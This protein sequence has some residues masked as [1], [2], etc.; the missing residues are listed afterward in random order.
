MRETTTMIS[1]P[2]RALAA[3]LC[4]AALTL[5]AGCA[6]GDPV[7]EAD[8]YLDLSDEPMAASDIDLA[9]VDGEP[10]SFTDV[11]DDRLTLLFFGYTSCPDVCPM[12]MAEIDLALG[13]AEDSADDYDVVMVSTDPAR[14]TDEQLRSWL[15]RFDPSF[16]GVRGDIDATVEA[17]GDYG[18]PIDAPQ[19]TEGQYLV[20]HGGRIVVLLPGGEAAGMFDEGTE[21]DQIAALLPA[22]ADAQL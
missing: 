19:E 7:A 14:D 20:T 18:I 22:L 8:Y 21:A 2:A 10:W 4:A 5:A 13:Q 3:V 15:D 1:R 16:Q 17:A 6:T 12:T 9:T 11:A